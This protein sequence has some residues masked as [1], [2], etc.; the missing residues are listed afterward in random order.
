MGTN[1]QLA[2]ECDGAGDSQAIEDQVSAAE[3]LIQRGYGLSVSNVNLQLK[4]DRGACS[5]GVCSDAVNYV[6]GA[7][8][9]KWSERI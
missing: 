7:I 5:N 4:G 2:A 1:D 3:K 9:V 8:N 6:Q